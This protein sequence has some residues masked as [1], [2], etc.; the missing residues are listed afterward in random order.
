[1][2][3]IFNTSLV[4]VFQMLIY[5]VIVFLNI[6]PVCSCL[7]NC[8]ADVGICYYAFLYSFQLRCEDKAYGCRR[9]SKCDV[10]R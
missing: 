4:I 5:L 8:F 9:V 10:T 7:R 1:M 3:S 2:Q 6:W